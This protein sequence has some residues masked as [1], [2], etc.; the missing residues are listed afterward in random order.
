[1]TEF[2]AFGVTGR[3]SKN[4][5]TIVLQ[6]VDSA[7][8]SLETYVI[9]RSRPARGNEFVSSNK[10]GYL[11]YNGLNEKGLCFGNNGVG[12]LPGEGG[13]GLPVERKIAIILEE[14]STVDE[15]LDIYTS[16]RGGYSGWQGVNSII[17][18]LKGSLV[19]IGITNKYFKV[20]DASEEGITASTNH[21]HDP[22]MSSLNLPRDKYISTYLRYERAIELLNDHKGNIDL[23]KI[24]EFASDHKYGLKDTSIC[25]HGPKGW[26]YASIESIPSKKTFWVSYENP[27]LR[28]WRG[29]T[30]G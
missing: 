13:P 19:R 7:K 16:D 12:L 11:P 27:C 23:F 26:T 10:I 15:A 4:G 14:C 3:G 20:N 29:F 25:R 22:E 6:N 17:G 24:R 8:E 18:D 5:N 1:M 30:V 21:F 2:T 28:N 9:M